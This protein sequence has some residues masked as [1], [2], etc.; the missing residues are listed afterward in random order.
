MI[1]RCAAF[2]LDLKNVAKKL[3][4]IQ[5]SGEKKEPPK[6]PGFC[7][8]ICNETVIY[9]KFNFFL[10][11][12]A[13]GRGKVHLETE[14]IAINHYFISTTSKTAISFWFKKKKKKFMH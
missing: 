1:K 7:Y 14:K 11:K 6:N 8:I 13:K 3:T 9:R 10:A 5:Q 4:Y 2:S 12:D